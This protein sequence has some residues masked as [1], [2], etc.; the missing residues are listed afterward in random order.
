MS[1]VQPW[2]VEELQKV[3]EAMGRPR[4]H[5][6]RAEDREARRDEDAMLV[7][8]LDGGRVGVI[9]R[10]RGFDHERTVFQNETAAVAAVAA[11]LLAPPLPVTETRTEQPRRA[12]DEHAQEHAR[13]Q[14]RELD[15]LARS[16]ERDKK[17]PSWGFDSH[18]GEE[19]G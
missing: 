12:D 11:E 14:L 2:T 5:V 4:D 8:Q 19:R 17:R 7:R 9:I 15:E 3:L 18:G 16:Q 1:D 6:G 10:G 13:K